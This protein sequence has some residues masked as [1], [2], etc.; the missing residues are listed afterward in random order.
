MLFGLQMS[1]VKVESLSFEKGKKQG[2][3]DVHS[4]S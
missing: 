3:I 4:S 1:N 2:R